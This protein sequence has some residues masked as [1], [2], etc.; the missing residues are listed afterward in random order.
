MFQNVY[1][2]RLY[3]LL[4]IANSMTDEQLD[5]TDFWFPDESTGCVSGFAGMDPWFQKQGFETIVKHDCYTVKFKGFAAWEVLLL[6]FGLTE[7]NAENIFMEDSYFQR[8]KYENVTIKEVQKQIN[9]VGTKQY[10]E[11]W[12][13]P[14]PICLET[15]F[16]SLGNRD[17]AM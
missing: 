9:I 8:N 1:H 3:N 10:G 7:E 16:V 6:F 14:L 15:R 2:E 17:V 4:R 12:A 5:L 11:S 13:N